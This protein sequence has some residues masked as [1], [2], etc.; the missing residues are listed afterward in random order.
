MQNASVLQIT[1]FF[2]V[3]PERLDKFRKTVV[4][5]DDTEFLRRKPTSAAQAQYNKQEEHTTE[6]EAEFKRT[7]VAPTE[8]EQA[9][10]FK[11]KQRAQEMR[12]VV[13]AVSIDATSDVNTA[14][15]PTEPHLPTPGSMT[16]SPAAAPLTGSQPGRTPFDQRLPT[17]NNLQYHSSAE[18][19]SSRA[20]LFR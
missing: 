2:M 19:S 4:R 17:P 6:E 8:A 5:F 10:Y 15:L 3:P 1:V 20:L 11:D 12:Q 16:D 14:I 9:Q 18:S 13:V 7:W